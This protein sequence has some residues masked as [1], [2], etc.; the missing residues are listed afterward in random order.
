M[1]QK[2]NKMKRG[3][4]NDSTKDIKEDVKNQMQTIFAYVALLIFCIVGPFT[5]LIYEMIHYFS[6]QNKKY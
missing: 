1:K 2:S 3:E 6:K 4:T 5:Y